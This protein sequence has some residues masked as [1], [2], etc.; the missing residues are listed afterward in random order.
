MENKSI[1]LGVIT[2]FVDK[3]A[4]SYSDI[5]VILLY[6]LVMITIFGNLIYLITFF[7]FLN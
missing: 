3:N 1:Y 7:S 6:I 5:T 4:R 2:N